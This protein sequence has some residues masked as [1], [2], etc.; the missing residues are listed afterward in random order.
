MEND[1][2]NSTYSTLVPDG[3]ISKDELYNDDERSMF[4][5]MNGNQL[6]TVINPLNGLKEYDFRHLYVDNFDNSLRYTMQKIQSRCPSKYTYRGNYNL[7]EFS[8]GYYDF[9]IG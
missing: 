7:E 8:R 3:F 6:K 2:T 5:T 4:A 1:S 9:R